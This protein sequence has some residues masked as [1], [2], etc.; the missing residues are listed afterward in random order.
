MTVAAHAPIR[1]AQR[2]ATRRIIVFRFDRHPLVCRDRVAL[3]RRLNPDVPVY[4]LYG[5]DRP[6]EGAAIRAAGR[7]MLQLDGL[8]TRSPGDGH[9]NWQHGDLA[10]AA[11]FV[12]IGCGLEF[13]VVHYLEWDLLLLASLEEVYASVPPESVG[14]TALT[15]LTEVEDRWEW[16]QSAEG[17]QAWEGLL[18]HARR[19]WGYRGVPHASWGPGPCFPRTFLSRFAELEVPELGHDELRLPLVAEALGFLL[20]DTGLRRGWDSPAE[21]RVFNLRSVEIDPATMLE[22]LAAPGGRRAFHPVRIRVPRPIL[23]RL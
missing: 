13:D 20:A 7:A 21:D 18:A 1:E 6:L 16:L 10:L 4:G 14:L 15:P 2:P 12:D 22:E 19:F 5:G 3:L 17:R 11:W 23:A 9:W 8:W